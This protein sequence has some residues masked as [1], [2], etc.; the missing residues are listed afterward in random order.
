MLPLNTSAIS[1]IK[2]AE[3]MFRR[4]TNDI[5]DVEH[6]KNIHDSL[7]VG[8]QPEGDGYSQWSKCGEVLSFAGKSGG[9]SWNKRRWGSSSPLLGYSWPKMTTVTP[10]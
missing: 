3:R 4:R 8:D 2:T 1:S 5:S 7:L 9:A 10:G 6:Y